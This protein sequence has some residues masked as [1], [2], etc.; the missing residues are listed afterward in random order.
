MSVVWKFELLGPRVE[1]AME[2]LL[3]RVEQLLRQPALMAEGAPAAQVAHR[4]AQ[5]AATM[6]GG[7]TGAA[8]GAG[9]HPEAQR[10]GQFAS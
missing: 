5:R 2:Q 1:A 9:S 6:V 8:A 3:A 4:G 10:P 7:T